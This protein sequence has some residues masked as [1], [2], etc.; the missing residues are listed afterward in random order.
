MRP[1][2]AEAMEATRI[3]LSFC[4]AASS[5]GPD[6]RC[7]RSVGAATGG[8]GGQVAGKGPTARAV[9][10]L[11]LPDPGP[12]ASSPFTNPG[13]PTGSPVGWTGIGHEPGRRSASDF[14]IRSISRRISALNGPTSNQ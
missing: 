6:V 2:V 4:L 8:L 9:S 14:T 1:W 7:W 10:E 12:S 5:K 13:E 11:E 3:E